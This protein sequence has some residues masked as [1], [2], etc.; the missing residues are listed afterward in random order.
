MYPL[1]SYHKNKS[2]SDEKCMQ[3]IAEERMKD[4]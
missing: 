2:E 3:S 1:I 4:L